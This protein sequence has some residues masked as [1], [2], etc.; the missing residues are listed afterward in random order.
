[1]CE[2]FFTF[3][4]LVINKKNSDSFFKKFDFFSKKYEINQSGM[5]HESR[6]CNASLNVPQAIADC[7]DRSI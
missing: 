7:R 4:N 5:A 3:K 6:G 2:I 1:M